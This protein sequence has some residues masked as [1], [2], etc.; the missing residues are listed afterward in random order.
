MQCATVKLCWEWSEVINVSGKADI[1]E[2]LCKAV[3]ILFSSL[4][5]TIWKADICVFNVFR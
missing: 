2:E 1:F 3:N 5:D 4:P